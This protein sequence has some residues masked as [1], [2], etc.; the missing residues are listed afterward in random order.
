MP[1]LLLLI[2]GF[3]QTDSEIEKNLWRVKF[4]FPPMK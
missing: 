4:A 2:L 3:Y 1:F